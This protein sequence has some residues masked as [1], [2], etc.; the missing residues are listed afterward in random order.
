MTPSRAIVVGAGHNGLVCAARLARA[1]LAVTVLEQAGR[2]GG[3]VASHEQ[4]LPGFV[5]DVCAG[6]FPLTLA[7]PAF[8]GLEVRERLD[9]A[10]PEIAMAHP[11]PDGTAIALHRDLEATVASLEA[12]APGAGRGWRAVVAPLLARRRRLL[13]A[14]LTPAFP[15]VRDGLA[16]A[17]ALR[18]DAIDLA[19]LSL[20]SSATFGREV[21]GDE[22]A[23]A[24]LS[25]SA[26][27]A[28]LTP[29]AAGGG[30][31]A[32]GLHL[33][34]HAV[35][36]GFPRGGAGRLTAALVAR[37]R[38]LGGEV[39]CGAPVEA[40][41]VRGGRV[42]GVRLS[43]GEALAA[44]AV[45]LA[46][47]A[48][49]A[50]ALLPE[51]ALPG[52]LMRRLRDWRY[53]IGTFKLDYALDGPVPWASEEARRAGVVHV[54]APLEAL[55]RAHQEAGAGRVPEEP[56]LVVGQHSL[57]DGSR[58]PAGRHTL[59]VYTHVPQRL[60]VP[61]DEVVERIERQL[62]RYAP[63]FNRLVLARAV[64]TPADLER[65][66]P[67]LVGG[68]LA[69][70]SCEIDQQLVFRPAP[71][72]FRGRTPLRGLYMGGTSVHPGAG[73]SGVPGAAAARALLADGSAVRRGLRSL[74]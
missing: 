5:H 61:A 63:G 72:L 43:G 56:C 30:A 36:W 42:A 11:W 23:A 20:A 29:G 65:E 26:V 37:V 48:R 32:F 40:V 74:L 19:R 28:D 15:P 7:S 17:L 4:T 1:G 25:S 52:R 49:P 14:A 60:D 34:G 54:G 58:A 38:E 31:L 68:D 47:S 6:F 62:V 21:M 71:E 73:V 64:R 22:R 59:Y 16:L 55:F 10:N 69:G 70:G 45:V 35:G 51:G 50:V 13:R 18:R 46:I 44:G 2:P 9:W 53:G 27:H 66:N 57:H 12:A 39:R 3:A 41:E 8:D 33:L 24:W 67:S